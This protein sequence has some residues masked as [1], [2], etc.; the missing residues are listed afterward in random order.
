MSRWLR[1]IGL[2]AKEGNKSSLWKRE[3]RRDL[4]NFDVINISGCHPSL[5]GYPQNI[6][7]SLA[8]YDIIRQRR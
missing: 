2:F 3:G 7:Y 1:A 4:I 5:K 8:S 6:I